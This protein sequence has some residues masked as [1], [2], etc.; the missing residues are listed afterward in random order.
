MSLRRL[1]ISV[2][3]AIAP[4]PDSITDAELARA[5]IEG[6]AWAMS[7]TWYRFAPEVVILAMRTLGSESEAEDLAQEVFQRVFAKAK[8]LREPERLRSFVF[9]F[10][11][12]LL[13]TELRS[14]RTRAW[15]SF[16]RP[17]TLVDLGA[18]FVD[19]ESRDLLRRFYSLLDRLSPRLRLVFVLRHVERMTIEEVA[20]HTVSSASTVKR[21]LERASSKLSVW[22]ESD[23]GLA[24]FLEEFADGGGWR[25]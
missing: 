24:A 17:E 3:L 21:D 1:P 2:P 16:H 9:S 19:M 22:I 15:L 12:R 4:E 7:Q 20:G 13:K 6:K 23:P 8:T 25:R 5:L 14:K 10:A 11:I 18:D